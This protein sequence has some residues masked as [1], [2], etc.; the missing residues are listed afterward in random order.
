MDFI[1]EFELSQ[2]A[3]KQRT[4]SLHKGRSS[5][6]EEVAHPNGEQDIGECTH[7][8]SKV[9]RPLRKSIVKMQLFKSME[10]IRESEPLQQM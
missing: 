7:C 6:V 8:K 4:D 10:D 9:N 2:E 3:H 1:L 5:K